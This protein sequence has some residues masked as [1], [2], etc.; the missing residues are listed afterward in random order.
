MSKHTKGQWLSG[1][2]MNGPCES[3][4]IDIWAIDKN[5]EKT[6]PFAACKHI[7]QDANARLIAAAP[8]LLEALVDVMFRHVPFSIKADYAEKARAAIAKATGEQS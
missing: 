7:D 4:W 1:Q 8:E 6:L 3:G 2:W 5:G